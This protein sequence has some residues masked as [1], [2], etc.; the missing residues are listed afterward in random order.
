MDG[1]RGTTPRSVV[2]VGVG[3]AG[4]RTAQE[5]RGREHW[6]NATDQADRAAAAI[7]GDAPPNPT[8]LCWRSNQYDTKIQCI[9]KPNPDDGIEM[10]RSGPR[11]RPVTANSHADVVATVLE[12]SSAPA[13]MGSQADI[14][15]GHGVRD[16]VG[17]LTL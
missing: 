2:I 8:V 10:I 11:N 17:R 6:N 4:L 9:D 14:L 7:M 3:L 12:F 13:V 16:I 1:S 5:L 15:T